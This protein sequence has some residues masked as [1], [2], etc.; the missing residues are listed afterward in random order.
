MGKTR[1]R[2]T[3]R[4]TIR[5]DCVEWVVGM[6]AIYLGRQASRQAG[7]QAGRQASSYAGFWHV[8]IVWLLIDGSPWS[9]SQWSRPGPAG[10]SS[11]MECNA[12]WSG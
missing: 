11:P 4:H 6:P 3:R 1:T 7:R 12:V 2:R 8:D 5:E 9:S 10:T